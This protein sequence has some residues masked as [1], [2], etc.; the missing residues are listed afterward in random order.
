VEA[1]NQYLSLSLSLS[2]SLT[3]SY[4]KL[5]WLGCVII[6]NVSSALLILL[7]IDK[8]ATLN[9]KPKVAPWVYGLEAV[10]SGKNPLGQLNLQLVIN[11]T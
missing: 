5:L 4:F 2:I 6:Q 7:S 1:R 9:Q 3:L 8:P 10:V 11:I